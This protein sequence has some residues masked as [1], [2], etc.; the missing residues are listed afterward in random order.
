MKK[1]VVEEVAA[2]NGELSNEDIIIQNRMKLAQKLGS[3]N[4][5]KTKT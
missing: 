1:E 3:P 2:T 5:R 4:A